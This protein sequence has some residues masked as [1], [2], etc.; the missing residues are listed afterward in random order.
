MGIYDAIL[1]ISKKTNETGFI[2]IFVAKYDY[3]EQKLTF[4]EV[5]FDFEELYICKSM[6]NFIENPIFAI[7]IR[8]YDEIVVIDGLMEEQDDIFDEE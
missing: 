8:L 1:E 7:C 3:K 2:D 6:E 4:N 5:E